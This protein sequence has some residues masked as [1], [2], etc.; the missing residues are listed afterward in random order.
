M[1]IEASLSYRFFFAWNP[2]NVLLDIS[3]EGFEG[4]LGLRQTDR[5]PNDADWLRTAIISIF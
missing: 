3:N 4:L 5:Q 1:R 2:L